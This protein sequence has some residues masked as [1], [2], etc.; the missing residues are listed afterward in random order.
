MGRTSS[1]FWIEKE[2]KSENSEKKIKSAEFDR[3]NYSDFEV[4]LK[5]FVLIP[6]LTELISQ[7]HGHSDGTCENA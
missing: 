1:Y 6:K 3:L 4:S 5:K 2:R 7:Y